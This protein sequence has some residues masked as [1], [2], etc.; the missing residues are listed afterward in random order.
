MSGFSRGKLSCL[1]YLQKCAAQ[2]SLCVASSLWH[3]CG[4]KSLILTIGEVVLDLEAC[5]QLQQR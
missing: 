4:C 1:Y 5:E 2:S 3:Y